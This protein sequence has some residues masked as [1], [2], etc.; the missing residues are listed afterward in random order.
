[1]NHRRLAA[2]AVLLLLPLATVEA[3]DFAAPVVT[4][5]VT[6]AEIA[7]SRTFVGS[8]E[9]SRV[10]VVGC[11]F[12]GFVETYLVEAGDGVQE[13]QPLCTL[14]TIFLDR[15]IE[16]GKAIIEQRTA[17]LE[18]L[19]NGA[20]PEEVREARA[21][22]ADAKAALDTATWKKDALKELRDK[23]RISGDELRDAE[24]VET[25]ARERLEGLQASLDLVLA[26]P[27]KERIARAQAQVAAADAQVKRMEKEREAYVI[28]AP[29]AGW[30]TKEHTQLGQWLSRGDPVV[31]IVALGEVDVVIP[32][33][34]DYIAGF[35]SGSKVVVHMDSLKGHVFEG[36]VHRIVP[37]ANP[38]ART[39]P[40]RIRVTNEVTDG[41]PL[42]KAGMF[43][44]LR[45][46]VGE[47]K[48]ALLV[49]KEAVVLGG[50]Q[51][52]VFVVD[53]TESTVAP[54]PVQFGIAHED[55]IQVFGALTPGMRVVIRGN[56]RLRPGQKVQEAGK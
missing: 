3:R 5:E 7:E 46:G 20:R 21:R 53:A 54:I 47:K 9:P 51:P 35:V 34:E 15:R 12:E 6:E 44:R 22:V 4:A 50:P 55:L 30:V 31:E 1:M 40:V 27:R 2:A 28:R 52:V 16:V 23:K 33:L 18:E 37:V 43:A 25:S 14:R 56:E 41:T 19:Q 32:V 45:F 10:S 17:E 48:K 8:V 24:L 13:N 36:T 49:P 38:R 39:F 26:G 29:F 42:I 11:E